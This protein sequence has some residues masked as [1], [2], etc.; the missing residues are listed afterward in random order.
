MQLDTFR[1]AVDSR[2]YLTLN[3]SQVLGHEELSFGLGSLEW[4]RHLSTSVDHVISA[5]LV[6]AMGLQLGPVPLEL[7]ASLPFTVLSG[8]TDTQ[9]V[10]DA[11][12]HL[13][14]HL[15]H[16]GRVGLAAIGSVYVPAGTPQLLGVAD[17]QLGRWRFAIQGGVRQRRDQTMTTIT[18]I[19][20]GVAASWALAPEKFELVGEVF[21]AMATGGSGERQLEALGGVKLYL[22]KNSYL[23][24]GAGRGLVADQAGNPDFRAMISIVFE[25]KA[26]ARTTTQI[27]DETEPPARTRVAQND[28]PDRDNDGI[29][30]DLDQCPDEPE[31]YNG[32]QD[33]D[34]CPDDDRDAPQLAD[35]DNGCTKS[36]PTDG[37]DCPD[38]VIVSDSSI[39]TLK[40]IEFEFNSAVIQKRS[41]GIL[42]AVADALRDNPDIEIVEVR[43]HTDERG[44]DEYNLDLSD[45]RAAS[46][47]TY[48]TAHGIAPER[49]TSTGYGETMP[50]DKAHNEAA[51]AKNRRV[52]FQIRKRAGS[53]L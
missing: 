42:N 23:S 14:A 31:T 25:P 29:R 37:T 45:R 50:I 49:L 1:P 10:G 12:L 40:S 7:G 46:V 48:L 38:R 27:P 36:G 13:K 52:E 24:L 26:A 44:N 15:G 21:G 19:P 4:G 33:D 22:A 47:V 51:W 32:Y 39:V 18:D 9:G 41:Y 2:G 35:H 16:I 43:G 8:A 3:G 17:A 11:G 5:T 6:A 53:I 34:G 20:V 30:D 28:F